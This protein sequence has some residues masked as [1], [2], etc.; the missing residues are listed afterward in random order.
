M[1]AF[2]IASILISAGALSAN[3]VTWWRAIGRRR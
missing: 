3:A 1:E 2:I